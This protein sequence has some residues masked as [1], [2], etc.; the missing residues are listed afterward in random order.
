M[1]VR[2]PSTDGRGRGCGRGQPAWEVSQKCEGCTQLAERASCP[3]MIIRRALSKIGRKVLHMLAP[4]LRPLFMFSYYSRMDHFPM[5][6]QDSI[7]RALIKPEAPPPFRKFISLGAEL[8]P[9]PSTNPNIDTQRS[10]RLAIR[11]CYLG[12]HISLHG[13]LRP[14]ICSTSFL[15]D[16]SR[17]RSFLTTPR[18][19]R[20]G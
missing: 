7:S 10:H 12:Q 5:G 3:C 2:E 17:C 11:A 20:N 6:T 13:L 14:R 9:S 8:F 19:R 18:M 4:K 16:I 1:N 15:L